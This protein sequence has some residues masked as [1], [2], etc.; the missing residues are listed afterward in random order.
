MV[1]LPFVYRGRKQVLVEILKSQLPK[2][3]IVYGGGIK[4]LKHNDRGSGVCVDIENTGTIE[5][6]ALIGADGTWSRYVHVYVLVKYHPPPSRKSL[7][8]VVVV[9]SMVPVVILIAVLE[10]V[11]VVKI[12]LVLQ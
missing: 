9:A 7:P 3:A 10:S 8:V 1:F 12:V 2:E 6:D 4:G 5:A 11:V